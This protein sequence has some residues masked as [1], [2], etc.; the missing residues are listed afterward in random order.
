MSESGDG[1]STGAAQKSGRAGWWAAGGVALVVALIVGA[2]IGGWFSREGDA[3]MPGLLGGDGYVPRDQ[4]QSEPCDGLP[5]VDPADLRLLDPHATVRGGV[6]CVDSVRSRPGDGRWTMR[7]V[8]EIP[9]AALP[10]LIET[11]T[12]PDRDNNGACTDQL[13]LVP[14][15]VLTLAD[16]TR[17]RPGLPGDGCHVYTTVSF[18]ALAAGPIRSST[19]VAQVLTEEE[20]TS[21]C[22]PD[23]KPPAD[24]LGSPSAFPV[25]EFAPITP[26]TR[27][28]SLCRYSAEE[29]D[30]DGQISSGTLTAT[31]TVSAADVNTALGNLSETPSP[32]C[33]ASASGGI[34]PGTEWILVQ[35]TPVRAEEARVPLLAI[36]TGGCRRAVDGQRLAL[37]GFLSPESAA[38]LVNAAGPSTR[39]ASSV[40][41]AVPPGVTALLEQEVGLVVTSPESAM[42]SITVAEAAVQAIAGTEYGAQVPT[43]TAPE[44]Y[45]VQVG[46]NSGDPDSGL[47]VGSLQW[48]VVYRNLDITAAGPA[49]AGGQPSE[50]AAIRS[51]VLVIDAETGA[52]GLAHW[53]SSVM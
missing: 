48:L 28:M 39:P 50:G 16:G 44:L 45:L 3:A 5:A 52:I 43:D 25:T 1:I 36:E 46:D 40:E 20:L 13:I 22:Q 12:V 21:G 51:A 31:G 17:I 14:G 10:E 32:Q 4:Q 53:T 33:S 24:W 38:A 37:L 35:P 11:L 30:G 7:D 19:P 8:H 26:G 49:G 41:L 18:D 34:S 27:E 42:V 15:F 9:A 29:G 47:A 2:T 23:S 6:V